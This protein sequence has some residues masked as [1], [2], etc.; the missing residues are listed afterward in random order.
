[1]RHRETGTI[2][3]EEAY[4]VWMRDI[5][6]ILPCFH[7]SMWKL[8]IWKCS[9]YTKKSKCFFFFLVSSFTL[10]T[11]IQNRLLKVY[12]FKTACMTAF[13]RIYKVMY[14]LWK[15]LVSGLNLMNFGKWSFSFGGILWRSVSCRNSDPSSLHGTKCC[16]YKMKEFWVKGCQT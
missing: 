2:L 7:W 5:N 6:Y 9:H 12:I 8:A 10:V 14:S 1:M 16:V 13:K 4:F 15:F 3:E 11:F